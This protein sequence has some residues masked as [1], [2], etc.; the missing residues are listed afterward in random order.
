MYLENIAREKWSS[1][2]FA[3]NN[4]FQDSLISTIP[5]LISKFGIIG[6]SYNKKHNPYQ[7][8]FKDYMDSIE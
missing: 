6:F 7:A 8:Y 3:F 1:F 2:P 5:N 4:L